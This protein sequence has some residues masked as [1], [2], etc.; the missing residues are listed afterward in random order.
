MYWQVDTVFNGIE[1]HQ[2]GPRGSIGPVGDNDS[3]HIV[4]TWFRTGAIKK[5]TYVMTKNGLRHLAD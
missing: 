2:R 5:S 4:I 3:S 1:V